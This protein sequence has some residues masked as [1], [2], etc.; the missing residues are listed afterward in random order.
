MLFL[1]IVHAI[2]ARTG[3]AR[4]GDIVSNMFCD[5]QT[6]HVRPALLILLDLVR[7]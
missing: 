3:H 6:E 5:R 7:R 1:V 4:F 2:P